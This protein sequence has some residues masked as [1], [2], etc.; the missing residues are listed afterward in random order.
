MASVRQ[1]A[2]AERE[3]GRLATAFPELLG[4]LDLRVQ[5]ASVE[6]AGTFFRVRSGAI[7]DLRVFRWVTD[8]FVPGPLSMTNEALVAAFAQAES[9]GRVRNGSDELI[10]PT[11]DIYPGAF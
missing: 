5:E 8:P 9:E 1:N 3:R 4:A 10:N 11:V 2:D 7:A 6:G